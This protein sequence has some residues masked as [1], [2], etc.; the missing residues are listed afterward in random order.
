MRRG[1]AGGHSKKPKLTSPNFELRYGEIATLQKKHRICS[2][3]GSYAIKMIKTRAKPALERA[4]KIPASWM[5]AWGGVSHVTGKP[6]HLNL[7]LVLTRLR[8]YKSFP[9]CICSLRVLITLCA[10]SEA[11]AIGFKRF[12]VLLPRLSILP[13]PKYP[14]ANGST[15]WIDRL[16]KTPPPTRYDNRLL[17]FP[18]R[19]WGTC[20]RSER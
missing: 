7:A 15:P 20:M 14:Y 6:Y 19:G 18:D 16:T 4:K 2:E 3:T 17:P 13:T 9:A 12:W 1:R 5:D 11:Q 8:A 10:S